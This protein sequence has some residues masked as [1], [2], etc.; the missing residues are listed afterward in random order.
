MIKNVSQKVIQLRRVYKRP[1]LDLKE[2]SHKT[3]P[4]QAQPQVHRLWLP[5][6]S[7]KQ[8]SFHNPTPNQPM[9]LHA[10]RYVW[11]RTKISYPLDITKV[12]SD[13]MDINGPCN[14]FVYIALLQE[15]EK[16]RGLN[17]LSML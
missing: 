13:E 1:S 2:G 6:I 12:F 14:K 16:T 9:S 3:S 11:H 10:H 5:L 8:H 15:I 4:C 7:L 17:C